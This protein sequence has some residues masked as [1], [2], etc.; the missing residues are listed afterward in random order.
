MG[1]DLAEGAGR[2]HDLGEVARL[3]VKSL[4]DADHPAVAEQRDRQERGHAPGAQ[5]LDGSGCQAR[6][7]EARDDLQPAAHG[8]CV[9]ERPVGERPD[10][11]FVV[12]P[13]G[14]AL[15]SDNAA[16]FLALESE[17][18]HERRVA[19][20]RETPTDDAEDLLGPRGA[21][22]GFKFGIEHEREVVGGARQVLEAIVLIQ[23]GGRQAG[24]CA[25][26]ARFGEIPRAESPSTMMPTASPSERSGTKARLTS[27]GSPVSAVR[28]S[29]V[30][31]GSPASAMVTARPVTTACRAGG[32]SKTRQLVPA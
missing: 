30:S 20:L 6:V 29:G 15:P 8:R 3:A 27:R 14:A 26:R 11:A 24:D 12:R 31:R 18:V 7:I 16:Q 32:T 1:G 21:A 28:C 10:G 23:N 4:G 19:Q 13:E 5:L 25:E 9:G 17:D 22:L 2:L